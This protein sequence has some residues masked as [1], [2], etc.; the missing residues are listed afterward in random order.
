MNKIT[1]VFL[2]SVFFSHSSLA[3]LWG[4][5]DNEEG[6]YTN[7]S[8]KEKENLLKNEE[9]IQTD[10]ISQQQ[11]SSLYDFSSDEIFILGG[12]EYRMGILKP[13]LYFLR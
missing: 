6:H 8:I 7:H 1:L 11:L 2:S 3:M 13:L 12:K 10:V 5:L 4:D 9:K